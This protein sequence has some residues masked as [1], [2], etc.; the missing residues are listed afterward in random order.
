MFQP[1]SYLSSTAVRI[2][3][4]NFT[5]HKHFSKIFLIL[6]TVFVVVYKCVEHLMLTIWVR[7]TLKRLYTSCGF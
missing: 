6:Q 2:E 5:D 1:E 7:C 4:H 3:E